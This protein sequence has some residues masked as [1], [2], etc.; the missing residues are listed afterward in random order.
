MTIA[1][2]I[3]Y[4]RQRL[5]ELRTENDRQA[6]AE[7]L[8]TF[9]M[10]TRAA[11]QNDNKELMNLLIDLTDSTRDLYMGKPLNGHLPT[12][13]AVR[14]VAGDA[15][16]QTIAVGGGSGVIQAHTATQPAIPSVLDTVEIPLAVDDD[17]IEYE[18]TTEAAAPDL[19]TEAE[20]ERIMRELAAV[21]ARDWH[22]H[23]P[24]RDG[25]PSQMRAYT[26]AYDQLMLFHKLADYNPMWVGTYPIG[27]D[28]IGSDIDVVC[29]PEN[30][31]AF[32]N[33]ARTAYATYPNFLLAWQLVDNM[34]TITVNFVCDDIPVELFAQP[35]P[36]VEQPAY[37]HMVVEA[38]LLA[39]GGAAAAEA[40]RDMKRNGFKTEPS[41]A[42]YFRLPGEDAF[43]TLLELANYNDEA[44]LAATQVPAATG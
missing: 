36:T 35:R 3:L 19:D 17:Y 21:A 38:R 34:P 23:T 43:Q 41:F 2:M 6:V 29:S 1:D 15:M 10:L 7:L 33:D 18:S 5:L 37:L 28:I 11:Y 24:I 22:D 8:A 20:K 26:V 39:I 42:K 25:S 9:K 27:L 30:L 40:I 44:L 14:L 16:Q 13:E 32:I 12:E 4:L 31:R